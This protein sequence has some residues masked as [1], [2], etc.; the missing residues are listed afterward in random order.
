MIQKWI[1][2][3]HSRLFEITTKISKGENTNDL[4]QLC[5]EELLNNQVIES[6]PDNQKFF[7][8]ARIVKNQY[9]SRNSKY[10]KI[11]RKYQFTSLDNNLDI[12]QESYEE[13][14]ITLEWVLQEVEKIKQQQWY[15]GQI[16]LLY[17]SKGAN[18]T[19]LSK[20]TGIPINSLSRDIKVVKTILN[21]KLNEK[22][23]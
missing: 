21:N 14:T 2:D 20:L 12:P 16:F 15:L 11:Y 17:L 5:M 8:Y 1:E 23:N 3:N 10:H 6:V 19:K 22:L 18:L 4:F 7:Y 9:L 13:P